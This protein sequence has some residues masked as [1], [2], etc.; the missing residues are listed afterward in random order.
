MVLLAG[1]SLRLQ[2]TRTILAN[3]KKDMLLT[4]QKQG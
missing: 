2:F 3:P 1:K 4:V